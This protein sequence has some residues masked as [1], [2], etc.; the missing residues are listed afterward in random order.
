[1]RIPL[2]KKPTPAAAGPD[3]AR[4]A[5]SAAARCEA[6]RAEQMR[7][8]CLDRLARDASRRPGS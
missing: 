3:N 7:L 1:L 8:N 5:G 2:G 6:M 4:P